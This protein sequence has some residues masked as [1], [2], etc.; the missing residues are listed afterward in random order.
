M[1]RGGGAGDKTSRSVVTADVDET[2]AA[3]EGDGEVFG[4]GLDVLLIAGDC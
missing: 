2:A 3:E 4:G 1:Q